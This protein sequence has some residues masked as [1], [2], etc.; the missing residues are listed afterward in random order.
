MARVILSEA[1]DL[2]IIRVVGRLGGD[3]VHELREACRNAPRPLALDLSDLIYVTKSG[4]GFLGLL[5]GQAVHLHLSGVS[6]EMQRRLGAA[7]PQLP[8]SDIAGP[9]HP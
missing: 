5:A 9:T 7:G 2:T 4:I 6:H 8:M 1:P 3:T